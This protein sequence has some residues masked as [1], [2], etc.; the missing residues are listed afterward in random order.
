M[1]EHFETFRDPLLS[2]YQSAVLEVARRLDAAPQKHNAGIRS[3]QRSKVTALMDIAATIARREEACLRGLKVAAVSEA[4]PREL[5]KS[6]IARV[7]AEWGFRYIKAVAAGDAEALMVLKDEFTAGTCD[8]EWLTTLTAYQSYFGVDG[9]R[10]P[11]PY[12]RAADVGPKTIEIRTDARVA[13]VGDWGTGANPAIDVLKLIARDQPNIFVHLGDIYYSGTPNECDAHFTKHI[14]AVL[15]A[16]GRRIP[17]FTLSGNH[18]MYCGGVG[19]YHLIDTLNPPPMTQ[20]SSFFCLRSADEKWQLL[21]MDTGLHDDDPMGVA[22]ALTFLEDDELAWHV[23]RIKE[24]RGRTILLSHHQP[25]SAFSAIGAP[26]SAKKRSAINPYLMKAFRQMSASG[27]IAAWFWG[28]EHSLSIYQPFA[29]LERGRCIG[30]GG[31]PVSVVDPIYDPLADLDDAPVIVEGTKLAATGGVYMH[32]YALLSFD[33]EQC[34]AEYIQ[35]AR[36]K[37]SLVYRES[38]T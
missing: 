35:D 7:C 38:F 20:L 9:Q 11:I 8:P 4:T 16:E 1:P 21:G 13:L 24:F 19:Y 28:H 3:L 6:G 12:R 29:G 5:S 14:D 22:E 23:E 32:G 2:L 36:G 30:H 26:N 33:G 17:V 34:K 18:D 27:R 15:R 25:F 37:R 31:V 10:K